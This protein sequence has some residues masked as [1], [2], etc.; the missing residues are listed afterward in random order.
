MIIINYFVDLS[1]I[2]SGSCFIN[3]FFKNQLRVLFFLFIVNCVLLI[4]YFTASFKIKKLNQ[5]QNGYLYSVLSNSI[6]K[7]LTT[8][9]IL[10]AIQIILLVITNIQ[11]KNEANELQN[12]DCSTESDPS[13]CSFI[14]ANHSVITTGKILMI[15]FIVI[16]AVL[17]T[18][19]YRIL[20]SPSQRVQSISED[21]S[22]ELNNNQ[23]DV[24]QQQRHVNA[25]FAIPT[26]EQDRN[27]VQ[28]QNLDQMPHNAIFS[29][30]AFIAQGRQQ[31][32]QNK[33]QIGEAVLL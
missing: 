3:H 20:N 6:K 15:A 22:N 13:Q 14:S 18:C 16:H 11:Q 12:V 30:K 31:N 32:Q 19:G 10:V 27:L 2:C 33:I 9:T 29:N 26:Q 7:T 24:I 23:A 25:I 17:F 4:L 21:R 1:N 28:G 8:I 5:A